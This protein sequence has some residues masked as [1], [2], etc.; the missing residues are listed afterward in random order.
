MENVGNKIKMS[1]LKRQEALDK[2][3]AKKEA[4]LICKEQIKK[5]IE[6]ARSIYENTI[7]PLTTNNFK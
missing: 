4:F 3:N 2:F 6:E 7:K 1:L 5:D